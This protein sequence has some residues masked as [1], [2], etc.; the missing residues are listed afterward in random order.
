LL[1]YL[2]AS[3]WPIPTA[4]SSAFASIEPRP[5]DRLRWR[6]VVRNPATA[7]STSSPGGAAL[8]SIAAP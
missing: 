1:D 5:P 6:T 7:A 2:I 4:T 8:R 3:S